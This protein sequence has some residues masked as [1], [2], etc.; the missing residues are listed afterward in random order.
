MEGEL[1]LG[2]HQPHS[3]EECRSVVCSIRQQASCSRPKR[4]PPVEGLDGLYPDPCADVLQS[5]CL[6]KRLKCIDRA[7][8]V[9]MSTIVHSY[10]F[11]T[12]LSARPKVGLLEVGAVSPRNLSVCQ[13]LIHCARIPTIWADA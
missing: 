13:H 10:M 11:A 7:Q 8:G 6:R 1:D 9:N 3:S 5:F 12:S 2:Q 4:E